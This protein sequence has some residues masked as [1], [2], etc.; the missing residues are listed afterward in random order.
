[1]SAQDAVERAGTSDQG[2]IDRALTCPPD[3][4]SWFD[5][6]ALERRDPAAAATRGAEIKESARGEARSGHRAARSL[7]SASST[8]WGRA[9][10]LA[11][12]AELSEAWQPRDALE[13]MLIDQMAV[14]QAQVWEWQ[15]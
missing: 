7:E 11:I 9:R 15:W 3:Q 6:N 2:T 8:C 5:L 10:F 14:Y 13:Q 4:G 12:C 1:L